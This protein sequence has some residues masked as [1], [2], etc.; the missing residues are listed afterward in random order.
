MKESHGTM[1][2]AKAFPGLDFI[3]DWYRDK[4]TGWTLYNR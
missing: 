3:D 2:M 1:T 4:E